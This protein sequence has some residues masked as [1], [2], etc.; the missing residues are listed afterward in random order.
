M[1]GF[2]ELLGI[3]VA[4]KKQ[5]EVSNTTKKKQKWVMERMQWKYRTGSN[6]RKES[7]SAFTKS[8]FDQECKKEIILSTFAFQ[9]DES[10]KLILGALHDAADRGVHIRLLVDGMESWIDMEG[11]PYF[12]G[13]SS[14]ENVEIKLYNKANPLK[15]W[16]MMGRMHDKYL[17]ADGKRYIL[18]GRNTYNYFLGDF[19][20]HKNY[21]RDVLVVC[22]EPE[23]ENSVNQLLEYFETIWEQEDSGYFHDNKN[24][25]IENL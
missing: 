7:R 8:A 15:P 24:W 14:H 13:L 9:S 5:P 10:G 3:C 4:Y 12:Y 20:G 19:P 11:N 16:K 1:C 22:D 2:Y 23:K 21:D 6:H 25:Q 17:I 18:G